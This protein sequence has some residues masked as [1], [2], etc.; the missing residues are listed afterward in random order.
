MKLM[1]GYSTNEEDLKAQRRYKCICLS[2]ISLSPATLEDQGLP[3]YVQKFKKK[4]KKHR[5]TWLPIHVVVRFRFGPTLPP[6]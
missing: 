2:Y 3:D 1:Y 4:Q 6:T 5:N